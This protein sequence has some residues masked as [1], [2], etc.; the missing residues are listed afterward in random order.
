M[1]PKLPIA[2][3]IATKR[4]SFEVVKDL[5]FISLIFTSITMAMNPTPVGGD[6][7][8]TACIEDI[9]WIP[10]TNPDFQNPGQMQIL[11]NNVA[12]SLGISIQV[13]ALPWKRCV[14][15]VRL[16][17][18]DAMIGGGD[19][20]Q[21]RVLAVFPMFGKLADARRSL[22]TARTMVVRRAGS[23][24]DWNGKSFVHLDKPVGV[25]MG[26]QVM[27][28]A[29]LKFG[30]QL[31]DGAKTD[32]QNIRKL[33]QYRVDL[34]AGYDNDLRKL[35]HSRYEGQV[36]ILPVPLIESHYYL[37]FSKQY[38]AKHTKRVGTFWDKIESLRGTTVL[39]NLKKQEA[40]ASVYLEDV[41][42]L[43][44]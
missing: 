27:K 41:I 17:K 2:M 39:K 21:N 16:G 1:I 3:E 31:D 19:A 38:Y 9:P 43:L 24:V 23:K 15:S 14:E 44:P 26:L 29:V 30:G 12:K 22:G 18:I 42:P 33:L 37:A 11:V 28:N 6:S 20:P 4:L 13:V 25:L 10:Y 40:S 7:A 35:I 32:D 36:D 8:F 5:K 34:L